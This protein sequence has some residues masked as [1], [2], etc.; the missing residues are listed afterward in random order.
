MSCLATALCSPCETRVYRAARTPACVC[1]VLYTIRASSSQNS[2][3]YKSLSWCGG[4]SWAFAVLPHTADGGRPHF[5]N[6][7]VVALFIVPHYRIPRKIFW[8]SVH[9]CLAN[10]I[11]VF[12]SFAELFMANLGLPLK[13]SIF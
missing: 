8:Y 7:H 3:L 13:I 1:I 6:F 11:L 4:A 10:C 9:L 12:L 2:R 5:Y